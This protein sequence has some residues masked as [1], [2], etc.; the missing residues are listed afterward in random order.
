MTPST[1]SGVTNY[2]W[3]SNSVSITAATG[4]ILSLT[5]LQAGHFGSIY[6]VRVNDGT[7]S[8][9]SSPANTIT[10]AVSQTIT[11]P[12]IVAG[13]FR[14]SFGTET[15][16]D[17]VTEFKTNLLQAS[18]TTLKTNAGTGGTVNVTNAVSGATGFYRIRLQ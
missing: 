15:G 2:Q 13:G 10:L 1:F 14:L 12:G 6:T 9:T 5:N 18:W 11:S 7:T 17:Y 8:V 3:L 4:R 16:P